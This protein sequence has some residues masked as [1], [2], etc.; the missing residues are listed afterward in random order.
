MHVRTSGESDGNDDVLEELHEY[1]R[2]N[3]SLWMQWFTFFVTVNYL[4]IGWFAQYITKAG[5]PKDRK[6]LTCVSI[7]LISQCIL[8]MW[9]SLI[10]RRWF[11]T[12]DKELSSQYEALAPT[13]KRAS[14]SARFYSTVMVL[15]CVALAGLVIAWTY[16][17]I[18]P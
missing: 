14:F 16:L 10:L 2:H 9:A 17:A 7:L 15:G 11:L 18:R 1:I 13:R 3:M 8:G 6:P 4:G 12:S 5:A